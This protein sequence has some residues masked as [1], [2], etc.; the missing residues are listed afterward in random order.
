[1]IVY[2]ML[3]LKSCLQLK[4]LDIKVTKPLLVTAATSGNLLMSFLLTIPLTSAAWRVTSFLT[5][6]DTWLKRWSLIRTWSD[7]DW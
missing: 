2:L 1:L 7:T 6:L 4:L 5:S 3:V